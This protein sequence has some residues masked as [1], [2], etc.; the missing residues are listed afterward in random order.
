MSEDSQ[1]RSLH[2]TI[3]P[4]IHS[5]NQADFPPPIVNYLSQP[6]VNIFVHFFGRP[7]DRALLISS[8]LKISSLRCRVCTFRMRQSWTRH[9]VSKGKLLGTRFFVCRAMVISRNFQ[10]PDQLIRSA[11]RQTVDCQLACLRV[12]GGVI[13]KE[14]QI[15]RECVVSIHE[16]S[17]CGG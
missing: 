3:G 5:G 6:S 11:S 14:Y 1:L 9:R 12:S 4:A 7:I 16:T 10:E 13:S 2:L 17:V 15:S 8:G